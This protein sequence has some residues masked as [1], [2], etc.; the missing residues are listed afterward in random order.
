TAADPRLLTVPSAALP[1]RSGSRFVWAAAAG[2]F[3]DA[4]PVFLGGGARL[5]GGC[6]GTTPERAAARAHALGRELAR[7]AGVASQADAA[8]G[9]PHGA[10]GA[11]VADGRTT[12]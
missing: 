11:Q 7:Q 3:G 1:G 12:S 10:A 9:P 8:A 2:Y 6:C 5:L 4:V